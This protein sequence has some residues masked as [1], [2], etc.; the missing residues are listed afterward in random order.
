M[1]AQR[2]LAGG[3]CETAWAS[4]E[5]LTQEAGRGVLAGTHSLGR[6]R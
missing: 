1:S 2:E 3:P 6:D 5:V 4:L